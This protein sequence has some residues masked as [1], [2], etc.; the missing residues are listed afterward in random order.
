MTY[1]RR[2]EKGVSPR[3]ACFQNL[4]SVFKR[5]VYLFID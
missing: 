4:T 3:R 1:D 5:K 2:I